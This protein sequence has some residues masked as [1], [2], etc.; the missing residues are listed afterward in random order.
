M[1][2]SPQKYTVGVALSASST[3]ADVGVA[4]TC[5]EASAEIIRDDVV[6]LMMVLQHR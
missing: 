6:N 1:V 5:T 4:A 2:L 3:G